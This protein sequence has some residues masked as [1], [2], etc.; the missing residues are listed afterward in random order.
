[1]STLSTD[2]WDAPNR[3]VDEHLVVIDTRAEGG[4]STRTTKVKLANFPGLFGEGSFT[5]HGFGV[6]QDPS[7]ANKI[8]LFLVNH[9]PSI[10]YANGGVYLDNA[11][12]GANSTIE[13]FETILGSDVAE[14]VRT[15]VHPLIRTPNDVEPA[16]PD[17]F[18]VSN[19]HHVKSG[20]RKELDMLLPLTDVVY[21]DEAGC[22]V[23]LSKAQ[24]A[25]GIGGYT[26]PQTGARTYYL[27]QTSS[28]SKLVLTPQEDN[29]LI[30]AD[31]LHIPLGSDNVYVSPTSGAAYFVLFPDAIHLTSKHFKEPRKHG[32]ASMVLKVEKNDPLKDREAFFGQKYKVSECALE[33]GPV[34]KFQPLISVHCV[35]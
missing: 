15:Y 20:L 5:S 13:I 23:A 33:G 14:H 25:N 30:V 6:W 18:Y 8:R 21:C 7:D 17:S 24:Y 35:S 19:D 31:T 1:M 34:K 29:T 9:R 11:K 28:A 27:S 4:F 2:A 32:S 12:V 16:G 10:D 3:S 26:S 22:K